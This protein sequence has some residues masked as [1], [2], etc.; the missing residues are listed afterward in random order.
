MYLKIHDLKMAMANLHRIRNTA[1]IPP[2][3]PPLYESYAFWIAKSR[4]CSCS[5]SKHNREKQREKSISSPGYHSKGIN[6][7]QK[8][9]LKLKCVPLL[10]G[11]EHSEIGSLTTVIMFLPHTSSQNTVYNLTKKRSIFLQPYI[12]ILLSYFFTFEEEKPKN[13]H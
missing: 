11:L 3:P 13:R 5:N 7:S 4:L 8:A 1:S 6:A 2:P 10:L 12:K 9:S